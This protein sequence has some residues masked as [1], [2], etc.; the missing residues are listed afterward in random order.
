MRLLQVLQNA[1]RFPDDS[2]YRRIRLLNPRIKEAVVD[3]PGGVDVLQVSAVAGRSGP[4]VVVA[5]PIA[6]HSLQCPV[7]LW[8]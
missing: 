7:G 3:V 6:L 5:V 4:L 8:L 1:A 2:K